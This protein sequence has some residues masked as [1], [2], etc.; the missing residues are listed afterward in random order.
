MPSDDAISDKIENSCPEAVE[1]PGGDGNLLSVL[2]AV[3]R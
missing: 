2:E 3:F 1:N